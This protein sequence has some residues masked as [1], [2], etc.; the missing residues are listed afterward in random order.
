VKKTTSE[1]LRD[2]LRAHLR[3]KAE[4]NAF[5]VHFIR[6]LLHL[7]KASHL[8]DWWQQKLSKI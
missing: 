5:P 3:E 2:L 7:E 4:V 6:F 8:R 1:E